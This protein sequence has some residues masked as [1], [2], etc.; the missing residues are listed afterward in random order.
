MLPNNSEA[1]RRLARLIH[2]AP[3]PLDE[4]ICSVIE[5]IRD[6]ATGS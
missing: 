1:T 6:C 2:N 4:I 3:K 5:S